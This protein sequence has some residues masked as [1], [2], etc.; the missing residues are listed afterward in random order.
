MPSRFIYSCATASSTR[1]PVRGK[2][3]ADLTLRLMALKRKAWDIQRTFYRPPPSVCE[4]RDVQGRA[5]EAANV[6]P[7]R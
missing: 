3:V 2:K 4:Y 1:W 6:Y 7:A 5:T